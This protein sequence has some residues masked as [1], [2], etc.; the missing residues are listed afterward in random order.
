MRPII[1]EPK[2]RAGEYGK[3]AANLYTHCATGCRYCYVPGCLKMSREQF[4]ANVAPAPDVLSRLAHDCRTTRDSPIFLC[5]TTDPYQQFPDRGVDITREAIEIIKRTG[6]HVKILTKGGLRAGRDMDLLDRGDEFGVT[7]AAGALDV[8]RW[9]P[10]A[11]PVVQRVETLKQAR[12]RHIKTWASF[13]PVI[14]PA[15]TLHMIRMTAHLLD[16]IAVGKASR[17]STWEWPSEER[18]RRFDAI[19]WEEFAHNAVDQLERLGVRYQI[20][21]DLAQHLS[22]A[23]ETKEMMIHK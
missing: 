12:R 7:L 5:F 4:H 14:D 8:G 10:R 19:D 1:Y 17:A 18:R 16:F 20:K 21:A 23:A 3:W 2:G 11:A 9:E 15:E 13:E 6:N 22:E